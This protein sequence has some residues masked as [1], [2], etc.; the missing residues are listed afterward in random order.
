[1]DLE[2]CKRPGNAYLWDFAIFWSLLAPS[3]PWR[4][5][6][7]QG[8]SCTPSESKGRPLLTR[9]RL[10]SDKGQD[11][12]PPGTAQPLCRHWLATMSPLVDF[13]NKTS[14]TNLSYVPWFWQI[15][16]L[17][18]CSNDELESISDVITF[19]ELVDPI[20]SPQTNFLAIWRRLIWICFSL[21]TWNPSKS[22]IAIY[23][24]VN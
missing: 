6:R 5:P 14:S 16:S 23:W 18:C 9:I 22:D 1:M 15:V 2:L 10:G 12:I 3:A 7:R 21:G 17:I 4:L 24:S 11:Q 13:K 19:S 20:H 8:S